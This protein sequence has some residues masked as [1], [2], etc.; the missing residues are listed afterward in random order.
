[1]HGGPLVIEFERIFRRS[2]R[3]QNERDVQ[4]SNN[5]LEYLDFNVWD[6]QGFHVAYP[7]TLSSEILEE[8]SED[9]E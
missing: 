6:E 2:P 1:M 4:M 8:T 5:D 7:E 3:T 9:E